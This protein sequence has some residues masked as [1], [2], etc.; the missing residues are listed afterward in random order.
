MTLSRTLLLPTG[1]EMVLACH[2]ARTADPMG[3]DPARQ[4]FDS[5]TTELDAP[6]QM[7]NPFT[8]HDP[9]P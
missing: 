2:P 4:D 7:P 6:A 3:Q 1:L 5:L 8:P 9:S